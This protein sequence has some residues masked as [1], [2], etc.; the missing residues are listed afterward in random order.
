MLEQ[1]AGIQDE[2][3]GHRFLAAALSWIMREIITQSALPIA[4][5]AFG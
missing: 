1:V 3:H 2:H 5:S 4:H